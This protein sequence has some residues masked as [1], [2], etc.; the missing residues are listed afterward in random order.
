MR[1]IG[2]LVV[3]LI[4]CAQPAAAQQ[5]FALKGHY[6][7]NSSA[8]IV[9]DSL[10]EANGLSVG[11]EVVFPLGI[12]I[13]V[14]GYA[15]GGWDDVFDGPGSSLIGLAEANYFLRLPLLPVAPYVGVHAG[16]GRSRE[17]GVNGTLRDTDRNQLGVQVGL[18]IQPVRM[19]G[20]DA[21]FRRVSN[22]AAEGQS[23][24]LTRDQIL[25]GITLF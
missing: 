16:L 13:G 22:S 19:F 3:G 11:A 18:R 23:G 6:L 20:L 21:Q 10:P 2:V 5:G 7:Y 1:W 25:V 24:S 8:R 4:L 14:S 15:A 12:G 9:G 17:R